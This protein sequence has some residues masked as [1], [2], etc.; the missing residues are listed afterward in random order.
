MSKHKVWSNFG[1]DEVDEVPILDE[2]EDQGLPIAQVELE[3][4][5]DL[6]DYYRDHYDN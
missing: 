6:E 4:G 5:I 2:A 1:E 3:T